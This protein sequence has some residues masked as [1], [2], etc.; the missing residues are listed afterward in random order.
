MHKMLW[1][2]SCFSRRQICDRFDV[3]VVWSKREHFRAQFGSTITPPSLSLSLMSGKGRGIPELFLASSIRTQPP[4]STVSTTLFSMAYFQIFHQIDCYRGLSKSHSLHLYAHCT[5]TLTQRFLHVLCLAG[6]IP[7]REIKREAYH[8]C[9]FLAWK[10][11]LLLLC[12][13]SLIN[14]TQLKHS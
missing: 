3:R 10:S 11:F 4:R 8:P 13:G 1:I 9:R 7:W 2:R 5:D 14:M 6:I 12:K